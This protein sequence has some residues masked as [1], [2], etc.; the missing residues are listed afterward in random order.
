MI[1][2]WFQIEL[3]EL[4]RFQSKKKYLSP[5]LQP[6]NHPKPPK[7]P[8]KPSKTWADSPVYYSRWLQRDSRSSSTSS[9]DSNQKKSTLVPTFNPKI[10]QNHPN[11]PKNPVKP[12]RIRLC[13][14]PDDSNTSSRSSSTSSIDSNLKLIALVLTFTPKIAKNHPNHPKNTVKP[15]RIRFCNINYDSKTGFR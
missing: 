10:T 6:Q 8:K 7:S 14:I 2:T 11:Y 9:I 13:T 5:D 15:G 3:D 12:E 4:Y 1:P